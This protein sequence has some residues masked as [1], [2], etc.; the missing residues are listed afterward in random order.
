MTYFKDY[1]ASL[2]CEKENC[3]RIL[4][5][6]S[7]VIHTDIIVTESGLWVKEEYPYLGINHNGLVTCK[8]C[9]ESIK[10]IKVKCPF[11]FEDMKPFEAAKNPSFCCERGVSLYN[12]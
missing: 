12:Q 4:D 2:Y 9:V 3:E 7:K 5:I 11:K 1:F 8:H 10:L 6:K